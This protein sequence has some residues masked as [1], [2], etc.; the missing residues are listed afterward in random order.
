MTKKEAEKLAAIL[1]KR[2]EREANSLERYI[3]V[4]RK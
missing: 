3:P 4:K 1:A 2:I